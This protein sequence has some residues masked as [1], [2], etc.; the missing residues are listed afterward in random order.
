M[1]KIGRYNIRGLLGRGGMGK[2]YKVELPAIGKIAAL[3]LL[4]PDPLL[5]K[6]LGR[7]KL[8]DLFVSEAKTIA[9]LHHPN[10]V[11][12]HDFDV[13]QGKPFYVMDFYADNLGAMI[14][15]SYRTEVP[16]R[17]IQTD[18]AIGYSHQ[19]LTGLACLHGAGIIH[20]DIKPFNLLVTAHD[21]IKICDFGL[22]KVR[23]ETYSGPTNLNVGSPYYAAPEQEKNPDG[24]DQTADL[25]PVGIMLFRMLTG[26]LPDAH[27]GERNYRPPSVLNADLDEKWD[28][29]LARAMAS[30]PQNRFPNA[31][32]MLQALEKLTLHWDR[33]KEKSCTLQPPETIGFQKTP[34]MQPLR[35]AAAKVTAREACQRFQLDQ[36]WRPLTYVQNTFET[37]ADNMIFDRT[38]RLIWQQSGSSY[39]CSWQ[40][41]HDYVARLN[42]EKFSSKKCWR[43]PT[44]D[45][46]ITLLRPTPQAHDLC[47]EPLFD[48]VQ[49]RIWS[50]DRRTYTAAYYV[51]VELGFVGR[52]DFSAP[53]YVRAVCSV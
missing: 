35:T 21:T 14:G 18:K 7:Q 24:V 53:Y 37:F 2:I 8:H 19:T 15:E 1:K 29:F 40:Q 16:S 47:I 11:A 10:I 44:V 25:Y 26:C 46:L 50:A 52:Q 48:P 32:G 39:P 23:G 36:L 9:G 28:D 27:P 45:E 20:R 38:T 5:A 13:D 41:A 42:T 43:L 4:D 34:P 30:D 51:D 17:K 49:R 31:D 12:V 33:Y 22:S 3:K 6:L